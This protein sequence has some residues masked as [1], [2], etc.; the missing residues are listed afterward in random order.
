L[1]A[2]HILTGSEIEMHP[3][4]KERILSLEQN[5][6]RCD[7]ACIEISFV[8]KALSDGGELNLSAMIKKCDNLIHELSYKADQDKQYVFEL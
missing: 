5:M 8:T 7:V 3:E 2:I 6:K 1:K 4:I